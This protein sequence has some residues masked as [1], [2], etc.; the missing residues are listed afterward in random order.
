MVVEIKIV[1]EV[2]AVNMVMAISMSIL[3][4]VNWDVVGVTSRE[5]TKK[6]KLYIIASMAEEVGVRSLLLYSLLSYWFLVLFYM[7]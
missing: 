5:A 3:V 2:R 7:D 6:K 4:V 1:I